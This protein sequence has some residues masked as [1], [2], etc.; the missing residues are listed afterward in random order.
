MA[1]SARPGV[2]ELDTEEEEEEDYYGI[3]RGDRKVNRLSPSVK[4][5]VVVLSAATHSLDTQPRLF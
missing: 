2:N 1:P 3:Q 5:S 4:R